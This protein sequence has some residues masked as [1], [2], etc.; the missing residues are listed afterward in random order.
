MKP[1][2]PER[3]SEVGFNNY[4]VRKIVALLSVGVISFAIGY[5]SVWMELGKSNPDLRDTVG[6]LCCVAVAGL[7]TC[8][9][10]QSWLSRLI[11]F[12]VLLLIG[13]FSLFIGALYY[14]GPNI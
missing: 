1:V 12:F 10:S 8:W 4:V 9:S 5:F 13:V 6:I 11:F 14:F 3:H 7:A 2:V